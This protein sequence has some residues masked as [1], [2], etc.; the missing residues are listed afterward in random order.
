MSTWTDRIVAR[1]TGSKARASEVQQ[2]QRYNEQG[3]GCVQSS[4]VLDVKV[5]PEEAARVNL[6]LTS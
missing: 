6:I 4:V 2:Y 1:T 5:R 3:T